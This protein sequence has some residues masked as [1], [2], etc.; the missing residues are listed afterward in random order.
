MA[1]EPGAAQALIGTSFSLDPLG[2]LRP[3]GWGGGP[4]LEGFVQGGG[5]SGGRGGEGQPDE[6]GGEQ[7]QG[8]EDQAVE[9]G[10]RP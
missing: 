4:C 3:G 10:P 2:A 7:A 5:R 6:E 1:V 9:N 8:A